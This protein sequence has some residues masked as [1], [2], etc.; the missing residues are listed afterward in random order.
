MLRK[1]ACERA[2][3]TKKAIEYYEEQGLI[4]PGILENG[5]R[6]YSEE[7]IMRLKEVSLLRKCGMSVQDIQTIVAS[8]DKKLALERYQHLCK[9]Q[10]R[11]RLAALQ[12]IQNLIEDYDVEKNLETMQKT[13][14]QKETIQE[15]V[16]LA[17]PGSYGMYMSLH[18][19][20][21]LQHPIETQEQ[22]HAYEAVVSYLDGAKVQMPDRLRQYIEEAFASHQKNIAQTLDDSMQESLANIFEN[23][24]GYLEKNHDEIESYLAYRTSEAFYESDAGK[25]F[26]MYKKFQES[27]GYQDIFLKNLRIL[28]PSYDTYCKQLESANQAFMERYPQSKQ[29]Q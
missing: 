8:K 4:Q 17:F 7:D 5:Y 1:Q 2:N 28:S 19:G 12:C 15:K 23:I 26:E 6:E 24:D 20:R 16:L 9:L 25:F 21:Y 18:F 3:I 13:C 27:S 10:E 14:D 22:K 11:K 29:M